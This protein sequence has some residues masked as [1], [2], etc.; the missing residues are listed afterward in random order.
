MFNKLILVQ[1]VQFGQFE[2]FL[3]F[4]YYT[5]LR[6]KLDVQTFERFEGRS[7]FEPK[8]NS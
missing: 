8:T 1:N 4:I 3:G 6:R 2:R 7:R 5:F